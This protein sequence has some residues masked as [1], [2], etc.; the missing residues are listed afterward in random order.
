MTQ[1]LSRELCLSLQGEREPARLHVAAVVLLVW[2]TILST[3]WLPTMIHQSL[4]VQLRSTAASTGKRRESA[5]YIFSSL[6][7]KREDGHLLP[8]LTG[9]VLDPN[10]YR[11]ELHN[12]VTVG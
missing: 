1:P 12:D 4:D 5:V 2:H 6:Q 10:K 3:A 11:M 7:K 9:S 8:L